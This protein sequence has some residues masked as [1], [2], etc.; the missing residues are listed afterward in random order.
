[1]ENRIKVGAV[2]Y[3]NTKPLIY[4][5]ERL[6]IQHLMEVETDYPSKV[7]DKLLN[8]QIDIGL[9]PVAIIPGLSE[10]YIDADYCIGADGPV[11]SVCLFSQ[12]PLEQVEKV[13]LDYQSRTSVALTKVLFKY[14]WKKQVEF[15]PATPGFEQHIS[16]TTAATVIGD[17][18]FA[19][20]H[21]SAYQYDLAEVWKQWTGLPF[22]FAAWVANKPLPE[23]FIEAFNEANAFGLNHIDEV[24]NENPFADYDLKYYFTHNISYPF[25]EAK[26]AGLQLFL[27]YLEELNN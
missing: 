17:R 7:A 22:V 3:L 25:N 13:Y 19:L 12:V 21:T 24:V 1:M 20:H 15:I 10:Y 16:G 6:P 9:V 8:G 27:K 18:A 4:G 2:S 26:R 23:A 14:Y 11:A 5:F